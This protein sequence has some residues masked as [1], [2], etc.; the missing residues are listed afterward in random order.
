MA[1]NTE[2]D[3]EC[4]EDPER[5]VQL[6]IVASVLVILDGWELW[7]FFKLATNECQVWVVYSRCEGIVY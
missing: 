2:L 5:T 1:E 4:H 6:N 3:N 7:R